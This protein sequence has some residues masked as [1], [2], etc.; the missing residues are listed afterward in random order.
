MSSNR[1]AQLPR[2]AIAA[3]LVGAVAL[4]VA[5]ALVLTAVAPVPGLP[6]P[7][8]VVRFGLPVV[9]AVLFV[10]A[11]V[12]VGLSVLPKL[13]GFDRPALTEPVLGTVRRAAVVSSAVWVLAAL[14]MVLLLV[15]ELRPGQQIGIGHVLEFMRKV[16]AGQALAMSAVSALVYFNIALLAVRSGESV[17]AELRMLVAL[18][19]LLPLP[20]G[21]HAAN[22]GLRWGGHGLLMASM[23]LH[24]IAASLWTGGLAVLV[25]FVSTRRDLLAAALPR[26]SKLATV[27]LLLVL[28]TGVINALVQLATTPLVELPGGLFTT[29]YGQLVLLKSVCLVLLAALGGRIRFRLLPLIAAGRPAPLVAWAAAE[30][31]VMGVAFGLA[32]V[33]SRTP[34]I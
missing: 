11:V 25:Y 15:A 21:G 12:T 29:G 16:G 1:T 33:L 30:V 18:F 5:G 28:V 8:A 7:G 13:L 6:E 34:V 24:V 19:A 2:A 32:V 31:V 17:P 9:R 4:G 27:C 10:A 3:G 26:F 22:F 14:A 20:V 23:E